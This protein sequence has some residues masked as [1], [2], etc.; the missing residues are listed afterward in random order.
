MEEIKIKLHRPDV[1][2]KFFFF[3]SGVIISVPF[4]FFFGQLADSLISVL[5]AFYASVLALTVFAPIIE[6]FAKA[7][8]LFY[9]H[10]ETERSIV[11]LGL[12][13]GLGFG[14]FEFFGYTIFL[15]VPILVRLPGIFFHAST[16]SVIAFG[17]GKRQPVRF[18]LLAV[19][20]H[21]LNNFFALNSSLWLV[22]GIL[23]MVA[24]ILLAVYLYQKTREVFIR[25]NF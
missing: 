24:T 18:Y 21:F 15:G 19:A 5:P 14:I 2:E 11:T 13:V 10:C 4:T 3:I 25:E 12:L 23:T 8:P 9:R 20:L 7:Y 16:T 6:E 17:V 22:G 1:R